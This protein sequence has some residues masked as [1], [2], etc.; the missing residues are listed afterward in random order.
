[1]DWHN[2]ETDQPITGTVPEGTMAAQTSHSQHLVDTTLAITLPHEVVQDVT[3]PLGPPPSTILE[4]LSPSVMQPDQPAPP[5]AAASSS[6][7]APPASSS[8][9]HVVTITC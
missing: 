4:S 5:S 1:M 3:I 6:S 2:T 7:A 8:S 9:V